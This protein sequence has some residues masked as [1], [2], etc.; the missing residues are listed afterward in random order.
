M[1][2]INF[3]LAL[4]KPHKSETRFAILSNNKLKKLADRFFTKDN[5]GKITK[6][7]L[8]NFNFQGVN[9]AKIE[10]SQLEA[11]QAITSNYAYIDFEPDWRFIVGLGVASVYETGIALHHIY[12][13]PYIP[14]S[15]IKGALRSAYILDNHYDKGEEMEGYALQD[16]SFCKV[17]GCPKDLKI[18]STNKTFLSALKDKEGN[19]AEFEGKLIF[20]D[21]FPLTAPQLKLDVMTPHYQPYYDDKEGK[22]PPADY[23]SPNPIMFLTVEKTVFRMYFGV[24]KEENKDLVETAK[25]WLEKALTERGIGAKTAVGYGYQKMEKKTRV[26]KEEELK[27][28]F[29]PSE[30]LEIIVQIE[31]VGSI[32]EA[33]LPHNKFQS[34]IIQNLPKGLLLAVGDKVKVSIK[35][36]ND[37]VK[38]LNYISKEE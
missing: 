7:E 33:K 35:M 9:F 19:H 31:K 17:F 13:I 26:K 4:N 11:A 18:K 15:G 16:D 22:K 2:E 20:F 12:G 36:K 38:C 8:D 1:E 37:K 32:V 10:T 6:Q 23:F 30:S 14:A 28:E 21:A 29:K 25:T 34:Y 3:S 24:K 27:K 5:K